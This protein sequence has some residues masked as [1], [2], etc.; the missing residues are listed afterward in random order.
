MSEY[1]QFL[2][3]KKKKVINSGLKPKT[4]NSNLF[5]FQKYIVKKALIAGKYAIFS[6]TGTGKTLMQLEWANQVR[7]KTQKPVLILAP[8]AVSGQTIKEG[9]KFGIEIAKY[10]L[11]SKKDDIFD[12]S[13]P[14][15]ITNYEQLENID[16]SVFSGIVLDES[17]ILKN[18]NGKYRNFIIEKFKETP[19]KLACTA[20]PSPNDPM[21]LGNH[22]EFLD[23]MQYNEMLAMY[24]VHDGGNTSK[25]KLKGHAE[26]AFYNW[27]STWAVML[28][29]PSDLGFDNEGYNLPELHYKEEMIITPK[30]DN[31][32]LF[33]D[34]HVNATDYNSTLRKT[35]ELRLNRV[36][37]IVDSTNGDQVIVWVKQNEEADYMKKLLSDYDFRDVRGSDSQLKK[38]TDL[39]DFADGKYKILITK[40]KIAQ[41]GLNFQSCH[42]Q[43]FAALDFSFESTYQ[44]IRRSWRF[45]QESEVFIYLVTTDTMEN[46]FEIINRKQKQHIKMQKD[47]TKAI[48]EH[49]A[50]TE[51]GIQKD[52]IKTE[53]YHIIK[54]DSVV[55]VK[56]IADKSI[57]FSIFSPPFA[58]LYTYSDNIE[59]MGNSKDGNDFFK[60]F[61][62][63]V[64]DLNRILKDG[65]LVAVHCMD[66]PISKGRDGYIGRR[67]FSGDIIR[68]FEA[69]N[70]IFHARVT[71]WKDPVIEMQRT[72]AL[73]LLH[74][75]I[76]KDSSLSRTGNPDYLVI[77][78]KH[79]ENLEP[80]ENKEMPVDVWQK[81]A[82]PVWMDINQSDTL[83][84]RTAKENKDEKHIC[85]LQLNV[86][87]RAVI[88]WSNPGDTVLT[89]FMGIGSEVWQSVKMGR[90][91]VGIELKNSYF[92]LAKK[93]MNDLEQNM[94]QLTLV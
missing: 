94:K 45:G 57:D 16:C 75:Q 58:S 19:Y 23:K 66:L 17:S 34:S 65:R 59:D 33:N 15:Y 68:L 41:F 8:L 24:F 81:Y 27:I 64:A 85:P 35:K 9:K 63:L 6:D 28:N 78:R 72:K 61:G 38:E 56:K 87:E 47:M 5:D 36:K 29:K 74:K 53:N 55:E 88:L 37:E 26:N 44:G 83:Q 32:K 21:E 1:T 62:F 43:I 67:D 84:F 69:N 52:E 49:S 71:I 73:G 80:I 51:N 2:K 14:I 93:N 7:N 31:G 11:L 30:T 42:V 12:H 50:F 77:F 18:F 40:L 25:W 76:K 13:P 60:H 10:K 79:G 92:D 86:I 46:V 48:N 70:F 54:G 4:L 39:L 22:S 90:K 82:S 3:E 20:T 91:G 89:P